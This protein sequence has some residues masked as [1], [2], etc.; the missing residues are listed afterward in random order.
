MKLQIFNSFE[1]EM[2]AT[3]KEYAQMTP[4]QRL[5]LVE[6]LR[7]ISGKMSPNGYPPRLRRVFVSTSK[8][9]R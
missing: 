3:R 4:S 7:R 9:P 1:E 8:A 2:I 6:K 5:D